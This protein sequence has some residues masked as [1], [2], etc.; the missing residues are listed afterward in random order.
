MSF[1]AASG[2]GNEQTISNNGFWPDLE[3]ADFRDAMRVDNVATTARAAHA[4]EASM[5]TANRRLIDY[6]HEQQAAGH[7]EAAAIPPRLGERAGDIVL[8]YCRAVWN[9]AKA[10]LIERYRDYDSAGSGHD[11]A[12][13][14]TD[15]VDDHR[16][17]AAWAINDIQGK[18]R[19]TVELI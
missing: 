17:Y 6:Q 5:L 11:R 10:E 4:L 1:I 7:S 2:T 15:V 14:L 18:P 16:R 13:A 3:L 9:L 8:L 19:T 12:D